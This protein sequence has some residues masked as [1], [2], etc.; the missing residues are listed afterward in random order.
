LNSKTV[1][2]MICKQ[3]FLVISILSLS[4]IVRSQDYNTQYKICS[5]AYNK[6]DLAHVNDTVYF[7]TVQKR[8]SCLKGVAAPDFYDVT[9]D[10]NRIQLSKLKGKV[11]VLDFWYTRCVPC[12]QEIPGFNK[13]VDYYANKNVVFIS[14]TFDSTKDVKKFLTEQPFK[15]KIIANNDTIRRDIFKLISAW[16]YSIIINKE[17]KIIDISGGSKEEKTFNYFRNKI[18]KLL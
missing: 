15:F 11:V 10:G 13:L 9:L 14:I 12:I 18:D 2:A 8:D 17:G 7:R 6:L 1:A 4:P 5:E 3:L 16:P